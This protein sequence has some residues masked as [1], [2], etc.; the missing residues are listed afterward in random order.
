M[1]EKR[2]QLAQEQGSMVAFKEREK[3]RIENPV[4]VVESVVEELDDFG[5]FDLFCILDENFDNMDPD[6]A[7]V[8]D[9]YLTEQE[10]TESRKKLQANVNLLLDILSQEGTV[11]DLV[12]LGEV[13]ARESEDLLNL[14]LGK[15][16]EATKPL[17]QAYWNVGMFFKN[18]GTNDL[19]NLQIMNVSS[20]AIRDLNDIKFFN[21]V[22]G[23]LKKGYHSFDLGHNISN[24]VIPGWL[25]SKQMLNKWGEMVH[26]YKAML[27]TDYRDLSLKRAVRNLKNLDMPSGHEA[28]LQHVVMAY[29]QII[30]RPKNEDAGEKDDLKVSAASS[31]A[32]LMYET[33]STP[34]S[35]PR[36]GMQ[37]GRIREAKAV[38]QELLDFETASIDEQALVPMIFSKN[39][40]YA[41]GNRTLFNGSNVG[42]QDYAVVRTFD[43]I[44][45]VL[46]NFLTD[47]CFVKFSVKLKKELQDNIIRFMNDQMGPDKLIKRYDL[48]SITQNPDTKDIIIDLDIT[49]FFAAKNYYIKLTGHEGNDFDAE[50]K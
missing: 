44:G 35:Q 34:L 40:V 4:E 46:M 9:Q 16:L 24:L 23:I 11:T 36:A 37:N 26:K 41:W 15:A 25:G 47:E 13:K 18:A 21:A 8:K 29:N 31:L 27:I 7:A 6:T 45:K 32:G 50:V 43:W 20:E 12:E 3:V 49:P 2:Q 1:E 22:E 14:N 48:K 30:A 38:D 28:H 39:S 10:W 42:L 19:E 33:E 17:E 5:G